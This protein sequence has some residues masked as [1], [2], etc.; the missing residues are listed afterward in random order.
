M[1][2]K[3]IQKNTRSIKLLVHNCCA[4]VASF[5]QYQ[6]HYFPAPVPQVLTPGVSTGPEQEVK[7]YNCAPVRGAGDLHHQP[8]PCAGASLQRWH[9]ELD[10]HHPQVD[11]NT[12]TRQLHHGG[13]DPVQPGDAADRPLQPQG[14][15]GAGAVRVAG[16]GPRPGQN[17]PGDHPLQPD[18]DQG[19]NH[20]PDRL[21][22]AK[23]RNRKCE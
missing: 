21:L 18:Q 9:L 7:E 6:I 3:K 14:R 2:N 4:E 23:R 20:V 10:D 8:Q 1:I 11:V 22:G 17:L 13:G 12:L 15:R 5:G 19:A 16:R